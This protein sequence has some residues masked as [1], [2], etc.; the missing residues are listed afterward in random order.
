MAVSHPVSINVTGQQ[1][2]ETENV[3]ELL[4]EFIAKA[5]EETAQELNFMALNDGTTATAT[6]NNAAKIS[7]LKRLQREL[8]GLPPLLDAPTFG[9]KPRKA[10]FEGATADTGK[11]EAGVKLNKKI[12]FDDE[13]VT[14]EPVINTVT[15][16]QKHVIEEEEEEVLKEVET[17]EQPKPEA[18]DSESEEQERKR[19]KKE[20]KEKKDK[21]EK[22]EK[23]EKKDKKEKK[24]K[25][26]KKEK[27]KEKKQESKV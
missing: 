25:K 22:K 2:L 13:P 17:D 8:R 19:R 5:D 14:V 9:E 27:R 24:E 11:I 15:N 7:Q 1:P 16:S 3:Q 21:K 4:D 23:K 20:K 18:S 26:D 6:N 12:K 10:G